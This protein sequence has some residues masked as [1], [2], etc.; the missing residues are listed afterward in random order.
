MEG[1]YWCTGKT[2][3]IS[4]RFIECT[5]SMP[6]RIERNVS[7]PDA[8]SSGAPSPK[9]ASTSCL[10]YTN[11]W[12]IAAAGTCSSSIEHRRLLRRVAFG[13]DRHV[14]TAAWISSFFCLQH[15]A[16][17]VVQIS[18]AETKLQVAAV[19]NM[20][21]AS[22]FRLRAQSAIEGAIGRAKTGLWE[23]DPSSRCRR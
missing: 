4:G 2:T 10:R 17:A 1:M 13:C 8:L 9:G 7:G 14:M 6:R 19:S 20:Q 21:R 23:S 18:G 12:S 22:H 3:G 5:P 11:G 15:R 16:A